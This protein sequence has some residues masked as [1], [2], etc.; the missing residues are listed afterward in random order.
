MEI[1]RIGVLALVVVGLLAFTVPAGAAPAGEEGA[2]VQ[3]EAGE[4]QPGFLFG[5]PGNAVGVRFNW[6]RA[7]ADSDVHGFLTEILTLEPRDFDAL[8]FA[9]DVG[10]AVTPRLDVR[11]GIDYVKTPEATSEFREFVGSDGLPI[12]QDTTLTQ[13]DFNASASFALIPRGRAIGQYAW[14]PNAVVPY[15][16]VGAGIQRYGLD[17]IGEFVDQ[18]DLTI[19]EDHLWS[20]GWTPSVHLFG[21]A[22][23]RLLQRLYLTVEARYVRASAEPS[24]AF[25]GF[26]DLDLSGMRVGAGIRFLF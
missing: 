11:A 25:E 2:A 10:F 12:A 7:R 17:L 5:Q 9:F 18:A 4:R 6:H 26:D 21:G 3:Q 13:T 8:G 19:F 24:D 20:N 16:G 14:I 1:M 22:D 23:I 15:V